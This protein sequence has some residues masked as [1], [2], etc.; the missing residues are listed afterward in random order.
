MF[1]FLLFFFIIPC[2]FLYCQC[3]TSQ[4]FALGTS[5]FIDFFSFLFFLFW[6]HLR[7]AHIT[8]V[9]MCFHCRGAF[10]LTRFLCAI[11]NVIKVTKHER[12][13]VILYKTFLFFSFFRYLSAF[14]LQDTHLLRISPTVLLLLLA[15]LHSLNER[16]VLCLCPPGTREG[17]VVQC[18]E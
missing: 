1:T 6:L 5:L 9:N 2:L 14:Y 11:T 18:L 12:L 8:I 13:R 7:T 17:F 4:R 10:S 15:E 16:C 3:P